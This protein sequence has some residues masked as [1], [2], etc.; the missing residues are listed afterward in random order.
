LLEISLLT[1]KLCGKPDLAANEVVAAA[2][3]P[4]AKRP[5]RK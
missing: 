4:P 2:K 1:H 3:R 5:A